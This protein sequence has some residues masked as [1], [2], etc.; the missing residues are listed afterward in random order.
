[1]L[2]FLFVG[3]TRSNIIF[4]CD[5]FDYSDL[6]DFHYKGL[7][8]E[9]ETFQLVSLMPLQFIKLHFYRKKDRNIMRVC[10]CGEEEKPMLF[11]FGGHLYKRV[12]IRK[13]IRNVLNK[14]FCF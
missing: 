14:S 7:D 5:D 10:I 6:E 12:S 8:P 11:E 13:I 3:L 9:I 2:I 1:M 4:G